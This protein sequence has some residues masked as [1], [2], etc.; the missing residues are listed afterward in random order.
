[1]QNLCVKQGTYGR[2]VF[3]IEGIKAGT[4][5]EC[6]PVLPIPLGNITKVKGAYTIAQDE[7]APGDVAK[8]LSRYVFGWLNNLNV[9]ALGYGSIYNH[10]FAQS[11]TTR[12]ETL[13]F[14][15]YLTLKPGASFSLIIAIIQPLSRYIRR[16]KKRWTR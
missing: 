10:S 8:Q 12:M 5:V 13:I 4:L 7:G 3:N 9:L 15:L 14:T 1:M 16:S 6:C 11:L 2:G